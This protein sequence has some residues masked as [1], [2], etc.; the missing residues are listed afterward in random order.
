MKLQKLIFILNTQ[1]LE[2]FNIFR[3]VKFFK[4]I[5]N[6]IK[7]FINYDLLSTPKIITNLEVKHLHWKGKLGKDHKKVGL[8][9]A[10]WKDQHLIVCCGQY[11]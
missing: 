8:W 11:S 4:R 6:N 9:T 3:T 10:E 5:I 1:N 2:K 7:R